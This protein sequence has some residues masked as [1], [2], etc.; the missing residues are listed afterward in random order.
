MIGFSTKFRHEQMQEKLWVTIEN[1][2]T[3]S[4]TLHQQDVLHNASYSTA[5]FKILICNV[6]SNKLVQLADI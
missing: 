1:L 4:E 3:L 2:K 5:C 6:Q